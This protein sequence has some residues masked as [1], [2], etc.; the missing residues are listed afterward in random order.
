M[1][2]DASATVTLTAASRLTSGP[3]GNPTFVPKSCLSFIDCTGV[4]AGMHLA[5]TAY[6]VCRRYGRDDRTLNRLR[7][8]HARAEALSLKALRPISSVVMTTWSPSRLRRNHRAV[9]PESPQPNEGAPEQVHD[10][11]RKA[12]WHLT[13]L[14]SARGHVGAGHGGCVLKQLSGFVGL[15]G[16]FEGDAWQ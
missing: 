7:F 6:R 13:G 12:R 9:P 8:S 11:V 10:A 14:E 4:V 5:Q 3:F 15:V 1:N 2:I 16:I